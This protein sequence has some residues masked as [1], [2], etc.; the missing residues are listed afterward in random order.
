MLTKVSPGSYTRYVL[1]PILLFG[2]TAWMLVLTVLLVRM[3]RH[4][5]ALTK[6]VTTHGLKDVLEQFVH[7]QN[8]ARVA[9]ADLQSYVKALAQEGKQH[10]TRLGIV[11]F[12]PFADTGG[13]QSF[14]MAILDSEDTGV[15]MTSLYGRTGNRWYV[16]EVAKGKG[17]DVELSREEHSAIQKAKTL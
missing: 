6:G 11:R 10:V 9:I 14:T 3:I 8:E 2:I 5:N 7:R 17:K 15:V 4:Y 12:N 1:V 13:A 16:K